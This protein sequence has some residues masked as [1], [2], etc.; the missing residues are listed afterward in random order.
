MEIHQPT[1]NQQPISHHLGTQIWI[2]LNDLLINSIICVMDA[3]FYHFVIDL[4]IIGVSLAYPVFHSFTLLEIKKF[5]KSQ[6]QWLSYWLIY[7]V[8][9]KAESIL[10]YSL[11]WYLH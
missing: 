4:I 6:V 11:H 1:F 8:T 10:L 7:A 9:I 2:D 3:D 5:D